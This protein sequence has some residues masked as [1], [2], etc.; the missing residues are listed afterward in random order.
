MQ[1]L[2]D[3]KNLPFVIGGVVLIVVAVGV[4]LFTQLSGNNNA[5]VDN[6]ADAGTPPAATSAPAASAQSPNEALPGNPSGAAPAG[7]TVP[8]T[9]GATGTQMASAA[10]G[11][12]S[13]STS[14]P[15]ERWRVDPFAPQKTGSRVKAPKPRLAIPTI[16]RIFPPER[17]EIK[18]L[19]RY[20]PQPPRRVAGILY[21]DK[22]NALIQTPDGWEV[23]RPGEKLS[24]GTIVEKIE[25][26]RVILRTVGSDGEPSFVEVR[27]AA[28]LSQIDQSAAGNSSAS[29]QRSSTRRTPSGRR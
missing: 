21:G 28:S 18:E 20:K 19:Q 12:A 1:W 4:F 7:G 11:N 22:V 14:R 17:V 23:K 5:P 9:P 16:P 25:R 8:G 6:Q 10:D 15:A 26:D 29:S 13:A 27:L 24:D 2:Q 3:K